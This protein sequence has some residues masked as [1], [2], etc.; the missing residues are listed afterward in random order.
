MSNTKEL[1]MNVCNTV[2]IVAVNFSKHEF[3]GLGRI[4]RF[5]PE[6]RQF[7]CWMSSVCY[8]VHSV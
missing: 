2:I 7:C 6:R 5:W 1:H 4:P 3:S 8:W